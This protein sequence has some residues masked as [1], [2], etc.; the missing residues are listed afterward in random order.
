M[1]RETLQAWRLVNAESVCGLTPTVDGGAI[2]PP[3]SRTGSVCPRRP[4]W[5]GPGSGK[6]VFL[7][8]RFHKTDGTRE[9]GRSVYSLDEGLTLVMGHNIQAPHVAVAAIWGK[10]SD[11]AGQVEQGTAP[12]HTLPQPSHPAKNRLSVW[13]WVLHKSKEPLSWVH[14]SGKK[15]CVGRG[16]GSGPNHP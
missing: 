9:Q 5:E 16:E 11:L 2:S 13:A 4:G 6:W 3:C 15:R 12:Q 14:W 10:H 8:V 7:R 1:V